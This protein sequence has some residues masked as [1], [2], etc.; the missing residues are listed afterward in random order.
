MDNSFDIQILNWNKNNFRFSCHNL[1]KKINPSDCYVKQGNSGIIVYLKKNKTGETWDSLEAK[2]SMVP[3]PKEKPDTTKDPT[4]GLMDMMKE[5]YQNGD[6]NTKRMIAESWSKA[7]EKKEG[8]GGMDGMPN[9]GGMGGMP[10]FGGG[11]GGMGGMP[12]FGGMGGMPNMGGMSGMPDFSGMDGMGD[13][14][15]SKFGK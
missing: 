13:M 5:M 7:Q 10:N 15:F 8:G 11:K 12:N 2:K 4:S 6:D 1:N 9:M 14:D 3:E